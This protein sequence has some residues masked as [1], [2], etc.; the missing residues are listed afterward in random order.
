MESDQLG[1]DLVMTDVSMPEVDG[2]TLAAEFR[3]LHPDLAVVF[4][5][6]RR[7]PGHP[8]APSSWAVLHKPFGRQDLLEAVEEALRHGGVPPGAVSPP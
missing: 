1:I 5:T 6:A 8:P 7:A 2:E 3:A 4:M